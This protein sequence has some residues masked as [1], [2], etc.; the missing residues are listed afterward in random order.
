MSIITD[1]ELAT[2]NEGLNTYESKQYELLSVFIEEIEYIVDTISQISNQTEV[3]TRFVDTL[4][5]ED[6]QALLDF[7]ENL[8]STSQMFEYLITET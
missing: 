2:L 5:E 3:L 7:I 4:S 8:P 6:A 1:E